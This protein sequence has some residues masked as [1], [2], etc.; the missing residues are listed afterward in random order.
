V[1]GEPPPLDPRTRIRLD[2]RT[3]RRGELV[4]GGSPLLFLRLSAQGA[5]Q[6]D[7]WSAAAP[8]GPRAAARRLAT[9]LVDAGLAHPFPQPPGPPRGDVD[10]VIPARDRVRGLAATVASLGPV[11]RVIV[12]DDGSLDPVATAA[13]AGPGALVV[14]HGVARGPAAARNGGWRAGTRALVA[15]VDADCTAAPDWLETLLPYF[16]D[17]RTGAVAPRVTAVGLP[18][19]PRALAVHDRHHSPLDLGGRPG[20]VRP[21]SWVPYVP[22]ACLVV[23]RSC[24]EEVNGFDEALQAGEDVDFVWR[25]GAAGW[26]VR[27]EP[28]AIVAHPV[29]GTWSGWA[30]QR[31]SYG[32]SAADLAARHGDALAP[33]EVSP[34]SAAAWVL[35]AMVHPVFGAAVAAGSTVALVRRAPGLPATELMRA[36]ALGHVRS[37]SAL[38]RVLTREWWPLALAGALVW[39]RARRPLACAVFGPPLLGWLRR[40]PRLDPVRWWALRTADGLAYGTG[41]WAGCVRSRSVA[42]LLP[43][44]SARPRPAAP[45]PSP[46]PSPS[47]PPCACPSQAV[48]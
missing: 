11:G 4:I 16:D 6:V 7:C 34:G 46:S 33:L 28:A 15:F 40:R 35:G 26:A 48:S 1:S 31:Y 24:L 17:P 13:A 22:T 2:G 14:R 8:V 36:A 27:Y 23:R 5:K 32:R 38:A 12:V 43:R 21:R 19:T 41:V 9:R 25:L 3:R 39:H 45:S 10:V 18:G 30:R 37:G 44:R 29:R 47:L 20:P 42:A